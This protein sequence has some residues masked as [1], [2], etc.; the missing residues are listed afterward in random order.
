LRALRT[1]QSAVLASLG[2]RRHDESLFAHDTILKLAW[3]HCRSPAILAVSI[4]VVNVAGNIVLVA[5]C[6]LGFLPPFLRRSLFLLD[7]VNDSA[8]GIFLVA[9]SLA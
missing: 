8:H 1:H 7:A 5:I 3:C 4:V 6:C 2:V 9:L